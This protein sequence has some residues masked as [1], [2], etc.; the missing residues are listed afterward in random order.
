MLNMARPYMGGV[1]LRLVKRIGVGTQ[2]ALCNSS[3]VETMVRITEKRN[4]QK[5]YAHKSCLTKDDL[6]CTNRIGGK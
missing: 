6:A 2:C 3:H 4:P 5:L 1:D